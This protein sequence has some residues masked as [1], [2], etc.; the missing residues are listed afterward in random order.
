[1]IGQEGIYVITGPF[2]TTA[3]D[4]SRLV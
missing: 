1:L 2:C 4:L 3:G